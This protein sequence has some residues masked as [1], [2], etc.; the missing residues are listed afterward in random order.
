M[1]DYKDRI[2][3][4]P[5]TW[6]AAKAYQYL[7]LESGSR[8]SQH[9]T[10][11]PQ[12]IPSLGGENVDSDGFLIFD[13]LRYIS[14]DFYQSMPKGKI[15]DFD[16]LINKDG[17]NTGKI[18]FAKTKPF[19]ECAVNEHLFI[20]RNT[21]AFDQEFI[22]YFLLSEKGQNQILRKVVG[23][24]QGGIN[25]SFTKGIFIPKPPKPEQ[26]TIAAVLSKVDEAIQAAQATIQAAEKLKKALMQNLLTGKLKPDGTWRAADEFYV[27]EKF[28]KVPKGWDII[29]GIRITEKITKGQSPKWQGFEYQDSGILFITSENVQNGYIDISEPKYLPVEFH[30]KIRN[31]QLEKGDVL[32]NIVGASIGRCAVFDIDIE[33]ANV[34]Q[35]VCVFRPSKNQDSYFLSYYIQNNETQRRLLGTQV[36]TAR[37]NLSLSDFRKFKFIIPESIDEQSQIAEKLNQ[38]ASIIQSKQTKI[39]TL[40]RLKKSLMQNLLTG[41]RRLDVEKVNQILRE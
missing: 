25:N 22:F 16:I 23:S 39:E 27:D 29:K 2:G 28:G 19:P 41:T 4:I 1:A 11:N 21:G 38:A 14:K 3:E 10:D 35:A 8:P 12:D 7:V 30:N 33:L 40:Q 13:N 6:E 26:T 15:I 36:E 31:S 34:N 17:A 5:D 9:V 18:A 37:A 20:I 32:I 24:A